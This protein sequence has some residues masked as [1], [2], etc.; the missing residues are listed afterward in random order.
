MVPGRIVKQASLG[1]ATG[2][3]FRFFDALDRFSYTVWITGRGLR[4]DGVIFRVPFLGPRYMNAG[5][6]ASLL[7]CRG[8]RG[9]AFLSGGVP[10]YKLRGALI[11]VPDT[12]SRRVYRG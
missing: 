8:G 9:G 4:T 11:P 10:G 6:I 12:S 3:G 2:D 5:G 7:A 1:N